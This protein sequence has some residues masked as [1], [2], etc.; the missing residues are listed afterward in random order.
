MQILGVTI[1]ALLALSSFSVACTVADTNAGAPTLDVVNEPSKQ[2]GARIVGTPS[3]DGGLGATKTTC[4]LGA[5]SEHPSVL[6][7]LKSLVVVAK[8]TTTGAGCSLDVDGTKRDI[9]C[10]AVLAL[11]GT[12][13][14]VGLHE[15]KLTV[16]S[17]PSG[18]AECR[19]KSGFRNRCLAV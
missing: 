11:P 16:A 1:M 13:L 9:A 14:G 15:L 12:L 5:S 3:V 2:G 7:D 6:R 8:A 18:P 17:G 10:G 19:K 4:E